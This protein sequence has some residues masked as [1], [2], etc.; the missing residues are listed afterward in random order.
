[1]LA[2]QAHVWKTLSAAVGRY[3]LV[4]PPGNAAMRAICKFLQSTD[5]ATAVEYAVMLA[6]ILLT[7][8]GAITSTGGETG[9]MWG[10]IQ[11]DI[12]QAFGN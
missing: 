5:G 2:H 1:M 10:A 9:G 3:G 12:E 7:M 11:T 4:L 8:I 6:L